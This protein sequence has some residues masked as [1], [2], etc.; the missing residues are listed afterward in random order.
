MIPCFDW[1]LHSATEPLNEKLSQ[2]WCPPSIGTWWF[3][4]SSDMRSS[5]ESLKFTSRSWE[6]INPL[7][8]STA[9]QH[10]DRIVTGNYERVTWTH[11][12]NKSWF[13][14]YA[15]KPFIKHLFL[16]P[17]D[18]QPYFSTFFSLSHLCLLHICAICTC[19]KDSRGFL[20]A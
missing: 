5:R 19:I 2:H 14:K 18:V 16:T 9:I 6:H 1:L 10:Y 15:I 12:Q 4:F 17:P 8:C 3:P 13:L 20:F 7:N 11:E